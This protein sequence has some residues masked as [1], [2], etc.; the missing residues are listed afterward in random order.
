MA[1]HDVGKWTEQNWKH[2]TH[3][4]HLTSGLMHTEKFAMRYI[5]RRDCCPLLMNIPIQPR[6]LFICF[7]SLTYIEKNQYPLP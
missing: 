5:L 3:L 2:D 1:I 4:H 7:F 6:V